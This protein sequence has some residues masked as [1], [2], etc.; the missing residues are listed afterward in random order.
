MELKIP[1]S[2][3]LAGTRVLKRQRGKFLKSARP[4]PGTPVRRSRDGGSPAPFRI[5]IRGK[6]LIPFYWGGPPLGWNRDVT[7]V[8]GNQI[9][10]VKIQIMGGGAEES[11]AWN[12]RNDERGQRSRR[13]QHEGRDS[14][15]NAEG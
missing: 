14:A 6:D 4:P 15:G 2:S 12:C 13:V 10:D 5:Q 9:C 7:V 11:N 1:F 8:A 3:S